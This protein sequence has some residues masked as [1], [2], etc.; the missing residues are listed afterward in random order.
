MKT[1]IYL[2]SGH[3]GLV[4]LLVIYVVV[5]SHLINDC[6]CQRPITNQSQPSSVQPYNNVLRSAGGGSAN[7]RKHT[8]NSRSRPD[9][10]TGN[11]DFSTDT[12][13]S[14]NGQGLPGQNQTVYDFNYLAQVT[15]SGSQP[16]DRKH[17][18]QDLRKNLKEQRKQ[19]DR[20]GDDPE[21]N[22]QN[23]M[24]IIKSKILKSD[25]SIF[26]QHI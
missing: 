6:H 1:K 2:R 23:L 19:W 12:S 24:K 5:L 4:G 14:N 18:F 25:V 7:G 13:L 3:R 11:D 16:H 20:Q 9:T 26:L 22:N 15:Q 17:T 21:Q 10:D 8:G